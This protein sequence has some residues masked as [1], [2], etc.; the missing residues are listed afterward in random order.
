MKLW[1]GM[2]VA[3]LVACGAAD[4]ADKDTTDT[5]VADTD[6]GADTDITSTDTD[7]TNGTGDTDGTVV[8]T[9][10]TDGGTP[11]TPEGTW[12]LTGGKVVAASDGPPNC[13]PLNSPANNVTRTLTWTAGTPIGVALSGFSIP[14]DCTRAGDT[15]TCTAEYGTVTPG[16]GYDLMYD[17][18]MTL[19]IDEDAGTMVVEQ[20]TQ[21]SCSGDCSGRSFCP[22]LSVAWDA[23]KD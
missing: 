19:E 12:S 4:D 2:L 17:Y 11:F 6:P 1:N 14:Y 18:P 13:A 16:P 7:D 23:T 8:D 5:D 10:E 3:C 9:D 22:T 20:T 21:T 15:V